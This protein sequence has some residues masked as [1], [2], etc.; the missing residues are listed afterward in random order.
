MP[1]RDFL[2]RQIEEMGIFLALLLRR[3]LKLKE[4][5]Q[6]TQ[7]ESVVKDTLKK[8]LELDVDEIVMLEN[9]EFLEIAQKHFTSDGQLEKLAEILNVLGSEIESSFTLT[10]ANY[11]RKSLLLFV[12]LQE[13]SSDFSFERKMKIEELQE[14]LRIH[15]LME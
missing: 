11:L 1:S 9:F 5:R 14:I 6:G 4:D 12:R 7:M 13:S 2:I 3:I 8:E 15:G 10:R